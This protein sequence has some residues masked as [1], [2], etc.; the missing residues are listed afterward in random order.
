MKRIRNYVLMAAGFSM[1]L[2]AVCASAA[3]ESELRRERL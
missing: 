1:A 2:G 3:G